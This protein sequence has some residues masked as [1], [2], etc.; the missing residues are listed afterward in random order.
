MAALIAVD[1]GSS[2]F[3]AALLDDSGRIL[4]DITTD[5][6][7]IQ[8][9]DGHFEGYLLQQVGHWLTAHPRVPMILCGMIGSRHGWRE[10]P[11]VKAPLEMTALAQHLMPVTDARLRAWIVPGVMGESASGEADVMRGEETQ[12]LGWLLGHPE[13]EDTA[14]VCLPGTH[15]KW[16]FVQ[17]ET[18]QHF[19]TAFSGE[20]FALLSEASVLVQGD[21]QFA[22]DEFLRGVEKSA[23]GD[24][25]NHLLFSVRSRVLTGR[26][27]QHHAQAYLS[28]LIVG[29]EIHGFRKHLQSKITVELVG[30]EK[31]T[32]AYQAALAFHGIA[33]RIHD[34]STLS[35]AGLHHL[36]KQLKV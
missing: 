24:A 36:S 17:G 3:R 5:Q 23:A 30:N 11:Y 6:G 32:S 34:G 7:V 9:L 19:S 25:L 21:Q 22:Q 12:I 33:C 35:F 31:V 10:V 14:I 29:A 27:E 8:R 26:L 2:R 1:W 13:R 15:T 18:L 4:A 16:A 20:L 28:G